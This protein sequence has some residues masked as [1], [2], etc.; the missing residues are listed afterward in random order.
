MDCFGRTATGT[1]TS[2][3]SKRNL[4]CTYRMPAEGMQVAPPRVPPTVDATIARLTYRRDRVRSAEIRLTGELDQTGSQQ[5][6]RAAHRA[7]GRARVHDGNGI[8]LAAR[9][10]GL[11]DAGMTR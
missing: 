8:G 9:A 2:I 4:R 3:T 6:A 11:A 7:A 5:L 10:Q 1:C